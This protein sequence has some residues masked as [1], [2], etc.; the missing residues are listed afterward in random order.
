VQQ[1]PRWSRRRFLGGVAAAGLGHFVCAA[2]P[3]RRLRVAAIYTVFRRRSHAFNILENFLAPYLFNGRRVDPGMDVVSFY[4]DQTAA[5]GDL[6][7]DV[8]RQ[9][10]ITVCRTIG[11]ALCAGGRELAVD[12]VLSIGE[13]G[14]Y[15]TSALGQVEYPRK[16]FFDECVAVMRRAQRFV[17]V[18]NDKHLSFR[19]DWARAMYDTS[20]D[21]GIP[22]MAGSSVPLAERRPALDLPAGARIAEAV[23]I[24]GGG[25]ESYD[26]HALENLQSFVEARQGGE[27]G[28]A[29]VEF[30][31]RDAL[32]RA[33]ADGRWS[34]SLAEA[35]MAA[36]L[37]TR[38]P[39]REMPPVQ[40]GQIHGILLTYRDG[41]RAVALKIGSSSIR[42]NFAC[43][44]A[45]EAQP[46]A[47]RF[48]VGPWGN[49][50]LFQALAHA[51]QQHFRDGRSPYPVE[52]TLLTTGIV[53]AAM[54]SRHTG[55]R[56]DTPHLAITYAPRDVHACREMGETW[57]LITPN[58]P[59][60]QGLNPG[61]AL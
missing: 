33:A 55:Q 43:R 61:A 13:H 50:N 40:N 59:E 22:L 34:V 56:I 42:W 24:H 14:N 60:P 7:R 36:E 52:R 1:H 31:P 20:R 37:G 48:Y 19:W 8:A 11:E 51:I 18:F 44:L 45:G 12:A 49:R 58:T 17:P 21:L 46:R 38:V 25:V 28:I 23:S 47:T 39:L 53:E 9:H 27:T 5:E 41:L 2:Q 26:F 35:A 32:L 3:Q 6:T 54:R 15:P 4:A 57:R 16:R 29:S 10:R 30:L